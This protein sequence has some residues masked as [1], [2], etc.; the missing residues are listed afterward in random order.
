M[1]KKI[2]I[3]PKCNSVICPVC[4]AEMKLKS[5]K[6]GEFYGCSNYPI[7][8]YSLDKKAVEGEIEKRLE[9]KEEEK[10]ILEENE[11]RKEME[12]DKENLWK[13]LKKGSE[14][15]KKVA[16]KTMDEVKTK[17]GLKYG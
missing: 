16:E 7:C 17:T 2:I 1:G 8:E 5:G 12:K 6:Y 15:A 10:R 4:G 3:C 9:E 11:K 14:K 13:I